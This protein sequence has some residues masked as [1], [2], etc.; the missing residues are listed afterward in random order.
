MAWGR[1][2]VP[3]AGRNTIDRST[4]APARVV[5]YDAGLRWTVSPALAL[6]GF[7]SNA[8]GNTGALAYVAD[9]EYRALGTGVRVRPGAADRPPPPEPATRRA[10]GTRVPLA[11]APLAP[12]TLDRGRAVVRARWGTHGLLAA[13]EGAIVRQLQAGVY[14]DLLRGTRDEGEL[15]ALA[16]LTVAESP[17]TR[18]GLVLAASRTNNPL[19]NLLA[20]RSDELQRLGLP[21]GGFRFGDESLEEGRLY[22]LTGAIPLQASVGDRTTLRA[23]PVLGYVQRHGVQVGGV[24]IGVD[25]DVGAAVRLVGE[26][27]VAVGRGNRLDAVGR[28][29]AVPWLLALAWHLPDGGTPG[30]RGV[31]AIELF[32]TNR[33]GDSPFHMLRVRSHGNLSAGIGVRATWP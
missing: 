13:L 29:P 11:L 3:L 23:A 21:K 9:R 1:G 7:V 27:G 15:G 16:R 30:R 26:S 17:S 12:A 8:L 14:L 6:D 10:S 31:A 18:L 24:T 25:R 20:A 32:A 22:T 4:G 28:S 33:A 2:F 5:T 19:V